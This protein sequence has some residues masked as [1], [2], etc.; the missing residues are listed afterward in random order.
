M[1]RNPS[2]PGERGKP[3]DVFVPL[4]NLPKEVRAVC[5]HA[6]ETEQMAWAGAWS[7]KQPG[8]TAHIVVLGDLRAGA[9]DALL[10]VGFQPQDGKREREWLWQLEPLSLSTRPGPKHGN[11]PDPSWYTVPSVYPLM[12][13]LFNWDLGLALRATALCART[14][15]RHLTSNDL[16]DAV[17]V[18]EGVE[19]WAKK[20]SADARRYDGGLD[21]LQSSW[22]LL[23]SRNRVARADKQWTRLAAL[24]SAS[25]LARAAWSI[26]N[27]PHR[28]SGQD[29][30]ASIA[31][32]QD[33][34]FES[35]DL[36]SKSARARCA[37]AILS[38]FAD[39]VR[40][41]MRDPRE[42]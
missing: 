35:R 11:E 26:H 14:S 9:R 16:E 40:F 41:H 21:D 2:R 3:W 28:S 5:E 33:A 23:G 37:E 29:L 13:S 32:A 25:W 36:K 18:I 38:E 22:D 19:T 30:V 24:L 8:R 39:I 15:L 42:E 10:E 31:Q 17:R 1:R 27:G 12:N 7:P 34:E 6:N 20:G 4:E